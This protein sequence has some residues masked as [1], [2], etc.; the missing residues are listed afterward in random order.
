MVTSKDIHW[1]LIQAFYRDHTWVAKSK[2]KGYT[3]WR[4]N[5]DNKL[6]LMRDLT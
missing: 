6:V 4:R 1:A 5:G 3:W 2:I